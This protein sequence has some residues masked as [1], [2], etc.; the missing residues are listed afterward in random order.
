MKN[1]YSVT[2]SQSKLPALVREVNTTGTSCG[3]SVR[4]DVKAYLV[5]REKMDALVE[6]LEILANKDAASA[7]REYE[8]GRMKFQS[9]DSLED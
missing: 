4:G 2:E 3:I 8:A 6:T 5:G 7:I 1:T 9:L